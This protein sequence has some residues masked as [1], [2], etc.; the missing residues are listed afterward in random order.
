VPDIPVQASIKR[1]N[2]VDVNLDPILGHEQSGMRPALIIQ[3]DDL[4]KSAW[5]TI[6]LPITKSDHNPRVSPL[7]VSLPRGE[8]GLEYDS[9]I[10][11]HQI[12]TLDRRRV[13]N[14]RG[15]VRPETLHKVTL[16]A[17]L[18]IGA[19]LTIEQQIEI[20]DIIISKK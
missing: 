9:L 11:C 1:G 3:D 16:A 8:A 14:V 20:E 19:P 10:L 18:A 17:M 2:V 5:C 4:G 13:I 6:I 15:S 12:R 7:V